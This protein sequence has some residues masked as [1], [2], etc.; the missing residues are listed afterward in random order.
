MQLSAMTN[1]HMICNGNP[2]YFSTVDCIHACA[3]AGYQFLDLSLSGITQ[4]GRYLSDEKDHQ[5]YIQD[6]KKVLELR[7][8]KFAQSHTVFYGTSTAI[9]SA[10]HEEFLARAKNNLKLSAQFGIPWTVL[11]PIMPVDLDPNNRELIMQANGNFFKSL[12]PT[13]D[14]TGVGIAIENMIRGQFIDAASLLELLDRLDGGSR[15]GLCWDTGHAN[16]TKQD[17]PASIKAMGK[18]L[19]TTHIADN[20]GAFDDHLLP[21]SGVISWEPIVDALQ[22]SGYE[23]VFSFEVHNATMNYPEALRPLVLKQSFEIG[24][25]LLGLK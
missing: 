25:H 8:V 6:V 13:I 7:G 18:N 15:F 21:F 17:Q 16:L 20:R 5:A 11:H 10:E 14:E 1:I 9:D 24:S 4:P 12:A 22:T 3:D 19:K 23:G 2:D